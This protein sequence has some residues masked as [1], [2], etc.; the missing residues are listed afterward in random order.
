MG[1]EDDA[2]LATILH[3]R[4]HSVVYRLLDARGW[5]LKFGTT[6]DPRDRYGK[7]LRGEVEKCSEFAHLIRKMQVIASGISEGEARELETDLIKEARMAGQ[8]IYNVVEETGIQ[9]R[10]RDLWDSPPLPRITH[11]PVDI[12][13]PISRKG[14]YTT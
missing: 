1:K 9:W 7:Y 3:D 10:G 12:P 6:N 2:L 11:R 13:R 14:L 8:A 5:V 4:V